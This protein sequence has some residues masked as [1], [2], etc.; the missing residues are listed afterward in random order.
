MS[1]KGKILLL[2]SFF[3]ALGIMAFT[4]HYTREKLPANMAVYLSPVHDVYALQDTDAMQIAAGIVEEIP[5]VVPEIDYSC[6]AVV[7]PIDANDTAD[8]ND[9]ADQTI[10]RCTNGKSSDNYNAHA[11]EFEQIVSSEASVTVAILYSSPWAGG[12][13]I[14]FITPYSAGCRDGTWYQYGNLNT[15]GWGNITS[16]AYTT[17]TESGCNSVQ[18]Y[19]NANYG[20]ANVICHN[21][22]CANLAAEGFDNNTESLQA[23]PNF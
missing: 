18:L 7:F 6:T 13:Y 15:I 9:T 8:K 21:P 19:A 14:N 2:M 12:Q 1:K 4:L 11:V 22:G 3:V 23:K 20:G 10:W 17:P 5:Q 16:S